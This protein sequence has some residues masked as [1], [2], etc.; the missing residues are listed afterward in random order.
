MNTSVEELLRDGMERFTEGVRA[1]GGPSRLAREAGRLHRRRLTVRTAAAGGTAAV[2]AAAVI[3]VTGGASAVPA[4]TGVHGTQARTVA[5]VTGQV[6]RAL[7]S[8]NLVFAGRTTSNVGP[9]MTWAYGRRNRF[10]EYWPSTDH[11]DRVVHDKHLWDFPPGDRGK[12]YLA[13]GSALVRGRLVS[14]YVTYFDRRY[15]LAPLTAQPASACSVKNR[16]GMGGPPVPTAHWSAFISATLACGGASVTGHVRIDGAETT[17]I[18]GKPVTIRLPKVYGKL[19]H[20]RWARV[21]WILWVNPRTYL[22]VRTYG[23]TQTFG[24]RAGRF[25][26]WSV[27]NVRWLPPTAG[28]QA[29]ALVTIPRGFHRWTGNPGNQ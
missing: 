15:G 10:E 11:R 25:T 26:S 5:Y 24:G 23:S 19:V 12:P 6:E 20:A 16:L 17:R 14:A 4:R 27:T 22:P 28:N 1:A 2:I 18:T 8:E 7:A 29:M 13:Q 21:R 9:S 3:A